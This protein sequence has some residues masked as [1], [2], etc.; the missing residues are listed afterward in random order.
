MKTKD[1]DSI[2]LNENLNNVSY[3]HQIVS[4]N[5]KFKKTKKQRPLKTIENNKKNYHLFFF[6]LFLKSITSNH[7]VISFSERDLFL[8][9]KEVK[10]SLI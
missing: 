9:D 3:Q 2:E 6:S 8:S 5:L 4:F 1:A 10:M 7:S